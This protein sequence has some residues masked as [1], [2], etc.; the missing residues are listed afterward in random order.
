MAELDI[1]ELESCLARARQPRVVEHMQRLLDEWRAELARASPAALPSSAAPAP[2]VAPPAPVLLETRSM[3]PSVGTAWVP[4]ETLSWDQDPYPS[5]FISIYLTSG[6]DG[7]GKLPKAQ[8]SCQFGAQSVD[9]QI[10]DLHGKNYRLLKDNLEHTI[11]PAECKCIVKENRVTLKMRKADQQFGAEHWTALT[12]KKR[13]EDPAKAADPSASLM[14]M[15]KDLYDDG[16]DTIRK[17]IGEA[18][19]KSRQQQAGGGG[20]DGPLDDDF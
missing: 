9:L 6:L 16:D 14:S 1:A 15:M 5:R 19:L 4:I 3:A 18:M 10:R 13:A 20:D 2:T 12:K 8:V 17:T 11:Q 7:V